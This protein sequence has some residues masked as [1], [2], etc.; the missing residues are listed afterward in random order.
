MTETTFRFIL[1]I[2]G[3]SS[4]ALGIILIFKPALLQKLNQLLNKKIFL[5]EKIQQILDK[6]KSADEWIICN[7]KIIGIVIV[8]LALIILIMTII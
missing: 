5:V 8:V 2:A 7:S 1:M 6:E 4:L 3:V